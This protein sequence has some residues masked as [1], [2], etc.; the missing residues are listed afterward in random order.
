V[1]V[2]SFLL[3]VAFLAIGCIVIHTSYKKGKQ[4][5]YQITET[6]NKTVTRIYNLDGPKLATIT[7]FWD[8]LVSSKVIEGY[9]VTEN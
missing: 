1:G 3:V 8:M 7:S 6:Q 2:F 4:M 5:N 9:E